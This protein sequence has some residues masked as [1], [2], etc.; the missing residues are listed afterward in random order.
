MSKYKS[1]FFWPVSQNFIFSNKKQTFQSLAFNRRWDSNLRLSDFHLLQCLY[2]FTTHT[3]SSN[4]KL[5]LTVSNLAL[6]TTDTIRKL[7]RPIMMLVYR[8][9]FWLPSLP[10]DL[11]HFLTLCLCKLV[12]GMVCTSWARIV[13]AWL[14]IHCLWG[15]KK[16][17]CSA[18]TIFHLNESSGTFLERMQMWS[19]G[20]LF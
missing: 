11:I 5:L 12:L 4:T 1:R 13:R 19:W 8:L 17:W 15:R 20:Q 14:T 9:F 3:L 2:I 18:A 10:K 6:Q 16:P 7:T